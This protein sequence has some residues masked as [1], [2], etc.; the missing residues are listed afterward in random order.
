[1]AEIDISGLQISLD[2]LPHFKTGHAGPCDSELSIFL[3]SICS[4]VLAPLIRR[5]NGRVDNDIGNRQNDT[6]FYLR[7]RPSDAK[8][9]ALVSAQFYDFQDY[10]YMLALHTAVCS[11]YQRHNFERG[12]MTPHTE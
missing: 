9:K 4:M 2:D 3:A 12:S 11:M 1:M 10:S 8:S 6:A 7:R 5:A